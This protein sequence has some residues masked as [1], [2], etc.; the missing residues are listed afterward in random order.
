MDSERKNNDVLDESSLSKDEAASFLLRGKTDAP[1][2]EERKDLHVSFNNR[3]SYVCKMAALIIAVVSFATVVLG[4]DDAQF[5]ALGLCLS[6][7]L[8]AIAALQDHHHRPK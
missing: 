5:V 3:I 6:I 8:L 1:T 4:Q 7:A 2:E